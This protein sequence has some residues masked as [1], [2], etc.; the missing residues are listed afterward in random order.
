MGKSWSVRTAGGPLTYGCIYWVV[1][2]GHWDT[3]PSDCSVVETN[4]H[5]RSHFTR[6]QSAAREYLTVKTVSR[7]NGTCSSQFRLSMLTPVENKAFYVLSSG[8]ESLY[9][10]VWPENSLDYGSV[11]T[12]LGIDKNPALPRINK[13]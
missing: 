6:L 2:W 11:R 12:L 9:K 4:I 3:K 8:V 7:Q 1:G 5:P 13:L 10:F